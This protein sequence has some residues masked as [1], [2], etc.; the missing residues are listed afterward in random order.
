MKVILCGYNWVG[1][2]ALDI[3]LQD[4][5]DVFVFTHESPFYVN[6]L[7]SFCR[8]KNIHYSLEKITEA[9]LPFVPDLIVS[10]Y[11]RYIIPESVIGLCKGK[12]FNL[13]PSLLPAYRGCSSLTWALINGEKETGF[14]YHYID[15]GIDTGKIILQKKMMIEDFDTQQ[16]LY[17]RVMSEAIQHFRF[18]V[19]QVLDGVPGTEQIQGK[20]SDY[21]KRGCPHDGEIKEDWDDAYKE[22]FIRA[23][24]YPPLPPA[25]F[26]GK[27]I[28][29]MKQFKQEFGD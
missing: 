17:L 18:V 20:E 9:K 2:K 4:N 22:R 6:D 5:H 24:I 8:K 7:E 29:S 10:M 19:Q 1:C 13:H 26:R 14:T 3:L 25:V 11:Y 12:I 15:K 23:M 21:Y 28:F 27:Q 16:T